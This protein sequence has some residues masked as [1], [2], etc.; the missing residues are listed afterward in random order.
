MP[1]APYEVAAVAIKTV[2]DTTFS[3]EGYAASHDCL[4]ESLGSVRTEIGISPLRIVT[5]PNNQAVEHTMLLIQ[6][7]DYWDKRIDPTQQVDPFRIAGYQH[8]LASALETA[9]AIVPGTHAVWYFVVQGTEFP[10]DP[11][12]N[13]TRFEM[14]VKA[15]GDNA[16][17]LESRA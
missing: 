7:Y 2:I 5:Q 4:H 17:L 8:R 9:Q 16:A 14:T 15:Y 6:F 1:T 13:K 12:G 3:T 10:R 11:T